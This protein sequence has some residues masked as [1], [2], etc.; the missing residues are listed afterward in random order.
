[1]VRGNILVRLAWPM[2]N[3]QMR[4]IT[5]KKKKRKENIKH[6]NIWGKSKRR[7]KENMEHT[8]MWC[9]PCGWYYNL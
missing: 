7:K 8:D 1:M 2:S 4:K 6:T 3:K 5:H 9:G